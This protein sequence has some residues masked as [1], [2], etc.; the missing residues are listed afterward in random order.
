M[1]EGTN[2]DEKEGV[3]MLLKN[4][5]GLKIELLQI[6]YTDQYLITIDSKNYATISNVDID[7]L[8]LKLLV[9]WIENTYYDHDFDFDLIC[10]L[11]FN[12]FNK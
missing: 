9:R 6:D 1:T 7:N 3:N 10:Q 5:E 4:K 11:D 2:Q 12:N 8:D